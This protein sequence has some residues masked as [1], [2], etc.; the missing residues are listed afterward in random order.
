MHPSLRDGIQVEGTAQ[1]VAVGT[2]VVEPG[3]LTRDRVVAAT[4]DPARGGHERVGTLGD[5]TRGIRAGRATM[6]GVVLEASIAR[7]IVRWGDDDAVGLGPVVRAVV[8]DDG[9]GDGWGGGPLVLA[10][11][12][13]LDV[14]GAQ[15]LDRRAPGG[16]GQGVGVLADVQRTGDG[17]AGAVLDDGLG[18]RSDVEVV[19]GAVE[20]G[21]SMSGSTEDNFLVRILRIRDDVVVCRKE[22]VHVDEV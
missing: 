9:S 10:F 11:G 12:D 21:A 17:L 13:D 3:D 2:A 16:I 22:R 14:I 15:H 19:E 8:H 1:V 7:R 4:L 6:W 18:G 5:P 20:G